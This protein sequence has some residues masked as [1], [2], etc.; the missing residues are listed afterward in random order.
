MIKIT[1]K[2]LAL[3]LLASALISIVTWVWLVLSQF[4]TS[5]AS[6]V[7]P[8]A[9]LHTF[10]YSGLGLIA[11]QA[12]L[13]GIVTVGIAL[14]WLGDWWQEHERIL[15][16][17][18][19][20]SGKALARRTR[21]KTW[22]RHPTQMVVAGVPIP[23]ACE[24]SHL[25]LVG[26]TGT[27]KSTAL[28]EL[29]YAGFLRGDRFIVVDPNGHSLDRFA[30]PED[31]VLNPFDHR[32]PG[33]CLFNEARKPYDYER[34]AKSVVPDSGDESSQAWHGYAQQLLSET[35]RMCAQS[36]E[37][38]TERLLYW[39]TA[40]PAP[41]LAKFLAGSAAGGLFE[42]GAEKAL[43]STRFILSSHLA[44]MQYIRPDG[45]SLRTWLE[46]GQGSL[47]ITWQED[48]VDSLRP[49]ISAWVDILIASV[50]TLPPDH[51]QPLWLVLDEL[52]SM[53]RLNS[54][55]AGLT[56]GRKHGLRV[57]AGLQSVAQLD[58][59][60]GSHAATTL[61]SCFRN[62]L[63][64]GC[65]NSDPETAEV[66]SKGLGQI[67]IERTQATYNRGA[68]HVGKSISSQRVIET[69]VM[70]SQLMALPPLH[71]YL[72]FAGDYPVAAVVLERIDY[73]P[74][75]LPIGEY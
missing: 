71:G 75:T 70:P 51:P 38:T 49:L 21:I 5:S 34:L 6:Q 32:S 23:P 7:L 45:F 35:M 60:Y 28:D 47:Y 44:A 59:I 30:K 27:G 57:V 26:S 48:M 12:G 33:W 67:E 43:A 74:L 40:A 39:T 8:T 58:A 18:R 46:S 65:A 68:G 66:I 55:E 1:P 72:K 41:E 25:L 3:A 62:I 50:L 13:M 24:T 63:A 9:L 36:G 69:L 10:E 22:R 31:I 4:P 29:Q 11:V 20:V 52:A 2:V 73:P 42:P 15:R 64:L 19:V 54:L 16:G 17:A 53:Q 37:P 61:R 56:K 14:A